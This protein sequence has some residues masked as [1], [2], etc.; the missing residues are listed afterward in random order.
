MA[1]AK[2]RLRRT[3]INVGFDVKK[4][5]KIGQ[6]IDLLKCHEVR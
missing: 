4:K 3:S 1:Y 6:K 2:D 5:Q